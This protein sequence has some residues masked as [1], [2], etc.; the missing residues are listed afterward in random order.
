MNDVRKNLC[1]FLLFQDYFYCIKNVFNN[2]NLPDKCF[3]LKFFI[4]TL[5][6]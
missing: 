2:V 1:Y 6:F 5:A 4:Q 3:A